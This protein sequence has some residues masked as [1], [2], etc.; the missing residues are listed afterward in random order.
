MQ[1][2]RDTW[3]VEPNRVRN[4][5]NAEG[6]FQECLHARNLDVE[7]NA[8]QARSARRETPQIRET[9]QRHQRDTTQTARSSQ[10]SMISSR[11]TEKHARLL[12]HSALDAEPLRPAKRCNASR[13]T[14]K[15]GGGKPI[16]PPPPSRTTRLASPL[17]GKAGGQREDSGLPPPS[18]ATC[19]AV[20][21]LRL[22]TAY[23]QSA[24]PNGRYRR[25][26]PAARAAARLSSALSR[27]RRRV[28]AC[29]PRCQRDRTFDAKA[30]ENA[31]D[32]A[33]HDSGLDSS[34]QAAAPRSPIKKE[35]GEG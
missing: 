2:P 1:H 30:C 32:G 18:P 35:R 25:T 29:D 17:R 19:A 8:S 12:P 13:D 20:R 33:F 14:T 34:R 9:P 21:P 16:G 22:N 7:P 10:R 11:H 28:R 31:G 6:G 5:C 26:A 24:T 23:L 3:L 27:T 15:K 4:R